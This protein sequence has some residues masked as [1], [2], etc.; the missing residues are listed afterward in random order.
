MQ[1]L[2]NLLA[3]TTKKTKLFHTWALPKGEPPQVYIP[4][5]S[6]SFSS[7]EDGWEIYQKRYKESI[8]NPGNR[9]IFL[10]PQ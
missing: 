2:V 10:K 4:K 5:S 9:K 6:N 3:P 8:L 1:T 7:L